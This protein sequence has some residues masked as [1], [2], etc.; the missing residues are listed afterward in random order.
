MEMLLGLVWD[1]GLQGFIWGLLVGGL[2]SC[3]FALVLMR[4]VYMD[5]HIAGQ[6]SVGAVE[7]GEAVRSAVRAIE[8]CCGEKNPEHPEMLEDHPCG[9]CET[10]M[11]LIARWMMAGRAKS[12]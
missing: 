4:K 6:K 2:S 5:A 3:G 1:E 10:N 11:S 7:P 9:S 12:G 8:E